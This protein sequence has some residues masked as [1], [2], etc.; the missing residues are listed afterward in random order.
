MERPES[1]APNFWRSRSG[2]GLIVLGGVAGFFLLSE[3]WAHALGLLP[4]ALVL[5]CPLMHLFM[6]HGH[7]RGAKH[8]DARD[9][10]QR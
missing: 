4:F 2:L 5:A 9:E 6:H 3:H 7:H 8:G 1:T 10:Q